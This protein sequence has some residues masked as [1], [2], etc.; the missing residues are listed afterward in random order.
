MSKS[1]PAGT[2]RIQFRTDIW[3]EGLSASWAIVWGPPALP[4][5]VGLSLGQLTAEQLALSERA[6]TGQRTCLQDRGHSLWLTSETTPHHVC[7]I[8]L[9]RNGTG[10]SPQSRGGDYTR[11]RKQEMGATGDRSNHPDFLNEILF[12]RLFWL[13]VGS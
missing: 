1:T 12:I 11:L 13:H 6:E 5:H 9:L 2:V 7:S 4:C 10:S 8:L 3:T